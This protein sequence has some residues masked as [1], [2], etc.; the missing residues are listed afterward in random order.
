MRGRRWFVAVGVALS[1][2][3]V[4]CGGD[5]D[6]DS[7]GGGDMPPIVLTA[8]A[9]VADPTESPSGEATPG[10]GDSGAEYTGDDPESF[11]DFVLLKPSDITAPD[12][13]VQ[14]DVTTDNETAAAADPETAPLIERCGRLLS[15]TITNFPPDSVAAFFNGT[16]L[17]YFSQGTLYETEEGA[18][19]CAAEAAARLAEPGELART[20]GEVFTS[21]D[22]VV[23]TPV[24]YGDGTFAATLRG[25]TDAAG[26]EIDLTI[27]VVSFRDRAATYAVGMAVSG[28]EPPVDE[29]RPYVDLVL[30]R[31]QE[32]QV[33]D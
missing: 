29:L 26:Q 22:G 11:L 2:T 10:S 16:T 31:S 18:T 6:G 12:W 23:V 32:A 27:L 30:Q 5:D 24:E 4:A 15:R 14:S 1:V 7:D 9:L 25:T 3:L 19:D 21:P 28:I 17:A 8:T 20:F 33:T 13:V